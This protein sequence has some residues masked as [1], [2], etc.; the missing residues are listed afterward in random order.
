MKGPI[1]SPNTSWNH[2]MEIPVVRIETPVGT[3][4]GTI[5]S[6]GGVI[7]TNFYVV[8]DAVTGRVEGTRAVIGELVGYD[9][10]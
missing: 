1:A 7:L 9:D 2:C 8:K 10:R 6:S 3:G 4:L 5:I